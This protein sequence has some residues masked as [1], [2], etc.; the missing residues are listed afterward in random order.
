MTEATLPFNN[1][2]ALVFDFDETLGPD[3]LTALLKHCDI[4]P[5]W[6]EEE[7]VNPFVEDGWDKQLARFYHL[8]QLSRQRDELNV[9]KETLAE[10]GKNLELY[11]E[12][13]QMFERVRGY[14]HDISSDI[15]VEF[16][17]LTAGMLEIPRATAIIDE[18]R[19][20]WGGE[21][22]FDDSGALDFVKNMVSHTDKIKYLLKLCKGLDIDSAKVAEDV[23]RHVPE[24]EWHV[25]LGQV[26]YLGDGDS[27]M[28]VFD[29]MEDNGGLAIAVFQGESTEDWEGYDDDYTDRQVQN[30]A[31]SDFR[32]ES[33][34]MRSIKLGVESI[35][36]RIQLQRM[37][38]D[39]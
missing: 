28:P 23:Y 15:E 35:A 6:F 21:L 36:R 7:L 16:Y 26:V 8:I 19:T 3:T 25:P 30:L 13:E 2:I 38:K 10:V 32:E 5:D 27:D 9:T 4:D 1:R 39:E 14:I 37:G 24:E 33:E 29:Y 20:V 12:V 34:L 31:K 17:L 22:H 11:P 18:F